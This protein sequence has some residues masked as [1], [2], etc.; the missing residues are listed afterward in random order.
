MPDEEDDP[1]RLKMG[2]SELDEQDLRSAI[3]LGELDIEKFAGALND[4]LTA[5]AGKLL[6]DAGFEPDDDQEYTSIVLVFDAK[7]RPR[8]FVREDQLEDEDENAGL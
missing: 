2:W 7:Q 5:H 1:I 3:K 4:K 8:V 6:A